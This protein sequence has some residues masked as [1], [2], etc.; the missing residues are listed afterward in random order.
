[1]AV[2]A[3][4]PWY[5]R[6]TMIAFFICTNIGLVLGAFALGQR[7]DNHQ[8]SEPGSVLAS[9]NG[10]TNGSADEENAKLRDSAATFERRLEMERATTGDLAKQVKAISL[11]NAVLKEDLAVFKALMSPAGKDANVNVNR[12]KVERDV[13]PGEYRYRLLVT[14]S[15]QRLHDFHGNLKLVVSL[16]QEGKKVVMVMPAENDK[17]HLLNFKFYQ[18]IEGSFQVAPNAVVDS[19]QVRIFENGAAEPRLTETVNLS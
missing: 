16:Q 8:R 5:L 10:N 1:M 7:L 9:F 17:P 19:L 18:R 4:Y 2:R 11:E 14:Q 15:G 13:I 3:R 12:F 6:W